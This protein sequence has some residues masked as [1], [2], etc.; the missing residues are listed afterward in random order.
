M[1]P[2]QAGDREGPLKRKLL[3]PASRVFDSVPSG[4]HV[5]E[6]ALLSSRVLLMLLESEFK[7]L[8]VWMIK[9]RFLPSPACPCCLLLFQSLSIGPAR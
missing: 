7:D 9:R 3:D 8:K 4:P 6:F 1:S 5:G 2:P